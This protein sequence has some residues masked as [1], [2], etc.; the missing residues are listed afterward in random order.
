[1]LADGHHRFETAITYR[2]ERRA[3]G[4]ATAGDDAVLC[5]VVELAEDQLWVQPIHRLLH[6]VGS[7]TRLRLDVG[8]HCRILDAAPNNPETVATLVERLR[9]RGGVGLVDAE[10][11][12]RL[13]ADPAAL[14]A[15]RAPSSSRC[16]S[17]SRPRGSTT[18]ASDALAAYDVTYRHDAAAVA[19]MVGTRRRRRR[20]PA[21]A[22]HGRPDPRR[23]RRARAHAAEDH[24]LRAEA[25]YRLGVPQPRRVDA[26]PLRPR[27][28]SRS[29]RSGWCA[30]PIRTSLR[31]GMC[32]SGDV[33]DAGPDR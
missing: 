27:S 24:V 8:A 22:R 5:L 10:G 29:L 31:L 9:T 25:P 19:A 26:E 4:T 21:A 16:S 12:A 14:D 6:G 23:R 7:A 3:D 18:V 15:A 28:A 20:D 2:D 32:V 33:P 17:T 11:V 1:M 13:V 30:Q